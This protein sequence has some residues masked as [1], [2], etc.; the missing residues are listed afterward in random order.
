[1]TSPVV[2]QYAFFVDLDA[3]SGCKTCQVAC[4]DKNDLPA[5]VHWRKVIEVTGGRWERKNGLWVSSV[6]AYNVSTACNHCLDPVCATVCS[7]QSI[8]KRD[9]GLVLLDDSRC[10][11]CHQC[12]A[13]CPY[14]A[15]RFDPEAGIVSKCDF[16]LDELGAGRPPACVAAC[17]NRALDWGDLDELRKRYGSIDRVF[18]L[19]DP[20][21]VRPA[22][23]LRPHRLTDAVRNGDPEVSNWG[24]L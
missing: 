2:T 6:A 1:M 23:V 19:P 14:G 16:C 7:T 5:G 24:E 13:A 4:K 18:P 10:T 20:A 21:S 8:W 11:R 12:E 3:C 15:I 17:P 9:D 22:L